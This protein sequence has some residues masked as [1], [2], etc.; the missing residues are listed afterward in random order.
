MHIP[1]NRYLHRV[2]GIFQVDT[3]AIP[4]QDFFISSRL[5]QNNNAGRHRRFIYF[6]CSSFYSRCFFSFSQYLCTHSS[7]LLCGS[8]II[9]RV[10]I[11]LLPSCPVI[12][13][14]KAK[15]N[16]K[17]PLRRAAYIGLT[18]QAGTSY[19]LFPL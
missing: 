3:A 11:L 4:L 15:M 1:K 2:L 12:V 19:S 7:Q 6:C 10:S 16:N 18:C 9:T 5:R 13:Q 8:G 17:K 14:Q